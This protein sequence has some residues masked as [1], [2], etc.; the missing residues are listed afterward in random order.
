MTC[1]DVVQHALCAVVCTFIWKV[2]ICVQLRH[3]CLS[4]R[5]GIRTHRNHLIEVLQAHVC[6][7]WS[8]TCQFFFQW[9]K[10]PAHSVDFCLSDSQVQALQRL[11]EA[12][13]A[14]SV[15]SKWT[16]ELMTC[17]WNAVH[18][19]WQTCH[20]PWRLYPPALAPWFAVNFWHFCCEIRGAW[21]VAFKLLWDWLSR[22]VKF[23][24]NVGLWPSWVPESCTQRMKLC[25]P[26]HAH[27]SCTELGTFQLQW[28]QLLPN[29]LG[30]TTGSILLCCLIAFAD[31]QIVATLLVHAPLENMQNNVIFNCH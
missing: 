5:R 7:F 28:S 14:M 4:V 18:A 31:Q 21:I 16:L 29:I 30:K 2:H 15:A 27:S 19:L 13:I 11:K 20:S 10:F 17:A 9:F 23:I 24:K 26:N 1:L 3:L 6:H 25:A 22:S 12:L 8:T